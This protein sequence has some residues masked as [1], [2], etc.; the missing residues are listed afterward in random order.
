M[1]GKRSNYAGVAG[2]FV[3]S[4][5]GFGVFH[6]SAALRCIGVAAGVV[7]R[8]HGGLPGSIQSGASIGTLTPSCAAAGIS[9]AAWRCAGEAAWKLGPACTPP[10]KPVLTLSLLPPNV[11]WWYDRVLSGRRLE[12]GY[13]QLRLRAEAVFAF[14]AL[15]PPVG[16]P[17][18]QPSGAC[19]EIRG[20][21]APPPRLQA[22][23]GKPGLP[24]SVQ[25]PPTPLLSHVPPSLK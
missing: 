9:L 10:Q 19:G 17:I 22:A 21:D 11:G 5:V 4:A 16:L 14:A 25:P 6:S 20:G 7:A 3:R 8:P 15:M 18:S 1:H 24:S 12:G 13:M 23:A 2:M